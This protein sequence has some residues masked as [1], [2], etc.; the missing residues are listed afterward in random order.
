MTLGSI[1]PKLSE[2]GVP[3]AAATYLV[4][5]WLI[6]EVGHLLSLILDMPHWAMRFVF[7]L[8][9][10]GFPVVLVLAFNSSLFARI[11]E[12]DLPETEPAA[13][14]E[15]HLHQDDGGSHGHAKAG[16][17][18]P[19]PFIVGGLM[20]LALIFLAATKLVGVDSGHGEGADAHPAA[21]VAA[22]PAG[23]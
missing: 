12:I 9:V 3:R 18:D 13:R 15:H 21:A 17:V 10:L 7:W 2:R 8:L 14:S 5:S 23:E 22:A 1:W 16:E 19:L 4:T 6:L 20:L 11:S